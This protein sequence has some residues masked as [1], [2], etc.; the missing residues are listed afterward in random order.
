MKKELALILTYCTLHFVCIAQQ[1]IDLEDGKLTEDLSYINY[2]TFE[3]STIQSGDTAKFVKLS[4]YEI[5][6]SESE[7]TTEE[8][9]SNKLFDEVSWKNS[10]SELSFSLT[11]NKKFQISRN[12]R[13][14]FEY[15]LQKTKA[16]E[17]TNKIDEVINQ[18]LPLTSIDTAELKNRV[19]ATK[20]NLIDSDLKT[21]KWGNNKI[22]ETTIDQQELDDAYKKL[23]TILIAYFRSKR[24]QINAQNNVNRNNNSL[25]SKAKLLD[26]DDLDTYL[27]LI[28]KE[29][30]SEVLGDLVLF[31][32]T[33]D[34]STQKSGIIKMYNN[35]L[36]SGEEVRK[37]DNEIE[38]TRS[39][40]FPQKVRIKY[41]LKES[42]KPI[43]KEATGEADPVGVKIGTAFGIGAISL[44][45][46]S[47][48]SELIS[49][50]GLKFYFLPFDK[51]LKDPYY[52]KKGSSVEKRFWS[53]SSLLVGAV[54]TDPLKFNGQDLEN[55]G[56]K[57]K[58][59]L[60]YS[61]DITNQIGISA[62]AIFVNQP[63]PSPLQDDTHLRVRPYVSLNFDFN[64][65][66]YLIQK[67][68]D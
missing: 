24:N 45:D 37:L 22:I 15:Y 51:R 52:H 26:A 46:N 57:I 11:M 50:Y 53:K 41:L 1:T 40:I 25:Q 60:G 44:A 23:N 62:G 31:L 49:I 42:L 55:T 35:I 8:S 19:N 33:T 61:Y 66:N 16:V 27:D 34:L 63:V 54:T 20:Q 32:D 68:N 4:V 28:Q 17:V 5:K 65:I 3:G 29:P 6:E 7:E 47:N 48:N 2:V 30:S 43:K 56:I 38:D 10:D 13:L 14:V 58:L 18:L 21:Y 67:E 59:V 9:D 64:V 39:T 12:Y 36:S